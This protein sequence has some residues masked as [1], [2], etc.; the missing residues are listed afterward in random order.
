MQIYSDRGQDFTNGTTEVNSKSS[1]KILH[2]SEKTPFCSG[3]GAAKHCSHVVTDTF[4]IKSRLGNKQRT[5]GENELNGAHASR[6]R[7]LH[8]APYESS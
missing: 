1:W 6:Q 4:F 5:L 3:V 7:Q 2:F 8:F